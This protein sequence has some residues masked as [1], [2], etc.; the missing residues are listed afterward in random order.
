[1]GG[2]VAIYLARYYPESVNKIIT[3]ATKFIWNETIAA[4]EIKMLN[5]DKIEEELPDFAVALHKRHAPDNW[6]TV[7]EKTAAMLIEM[8]K[9]TRSNGAITQ[10][11]NTRF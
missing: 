7:L 9:R 5:A 2:Y 10:L 3:L 1:M 11:F 6:K 8:G 4:K